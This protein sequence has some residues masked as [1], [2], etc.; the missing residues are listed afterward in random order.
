MKRL[1]TVCIGNICRSPLAE[2]ALR[3]ALGDGWQ[4]SSAGLQ[5]L[6]GMPADPTSQAIALEQ[7]LD[8]SAHRAQQLSAWMT[9]QHD[10]ILVMEDAHTRLLLQ[11]APTARGKVFRLGHVRGYDI[12][13]PYQQSRDAFDTAWAGIVQGVDDWVPRLRRL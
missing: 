2:V 1:L 11:M 3:R 13:D 9:Q 4:V 12:A 5:A 7:G 6:V 8:L 10:V